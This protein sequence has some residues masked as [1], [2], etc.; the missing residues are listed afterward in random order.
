MAAH[1]IRQLC[2]TVFEGAQVQEAARLA[3]VIDRIVVPQEGLAMEP[4]GGL[5]EVGS[6]ILGGADFGAGPEDI[7]AP[8]EPLTQ[9]L[10][11][12]GGMAPNTFSST[13]SVL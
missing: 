1:E 13:G 3:A 10:Q 12:V 4:V 6:R 2:R 7:D 9:I 8:V 5:F 11:I